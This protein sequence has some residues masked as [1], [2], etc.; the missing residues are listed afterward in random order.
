MIAPL[1]G[2]RVLDVSRFVSGP[3]CTFFLASL[4]AEVIAVEGP[5]PSPSRMLPPFAAPGGGAT[6]EPVEGAIAMPFLKRARGKRSVAIDLTH[7]EGQELVRSL[8]QWC[9]VFVDNSSPG[10]MA[11]FGL[12]YDDLSALNGSLVYCAIS[13]YGQDAPDRP[14]MDNIV[15]AMSG[16]MAKTGFADGPPLRSGITVADHTTAVF[17]ALGVTAALRQ[18]DAT[19]RGQLVDVAMID[20]L[21]ALVWDEPVDHY[22]AIGLP[23]RTGNADPR[24][25]PINTYRCADGWVSV[26]CTSDV[27]FER[28]CEAIGR[29]DLRDRFPDQRARAAGSAEID[30]ELE[31]WSAALPVDE[32][33]AVF[34][35][36]GMPAGR[37]RD[38]VEAVGDPAVVARGL[39][40]EL[41][42]PD[43]PAG[44]PSGY[45]GARL[46]IVF[47]G[48]VE[49]APAEPLGASTEAVLRELGGCDAATITRLRAAG[50]IG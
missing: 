29:A 44:R 36:S 27:Q 2:I 45:L 13:G 5:R 41:R 33:E 4:G 35:A 28:L 1:Q 49:L 40:E 12:S 21:T 8:V 11:R 43:A 48:R 19:G 46:P 37:V 3:L 39:M 30:R 15:Q 38:P 18:R 25:A 20:V 6:T 9:D 26:T 17:A 24:G 31:V 7:P 42:H 47:D 50:V 10:V 32:V 34:L 22:A 16:L 14:A 23:V